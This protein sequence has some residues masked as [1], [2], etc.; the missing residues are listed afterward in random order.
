MTF[1]TKLQFLSGDRPQ[2]DEQVSE[3]KTLLERKGAECKGPHAEPPTEKYVPQYATLQPG[4]QFDSWGYTVY[5][6]KLEIHGND[7]TAKEVAMM[8]FP[9]TIRVEITV[10]QKHPS[11]FPQNS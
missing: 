6:R 3:L 11:G 2:L 10:E 8:D 5:S 1:V 4:Q 9:S 7:H